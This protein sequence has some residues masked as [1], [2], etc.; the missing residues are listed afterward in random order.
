MSVAR[1]V[2]RFLMKHAYAAAALCLTPYPTT[3]WTIDVTD[4]PDQTYLGVFAPIASQSTVFSLTYDYYL[5]PLLAQFAA[6]CL[7]VFAITRAPG[8]LGLRQPRTF[9][10]AGA[11]VA[12]VCAALS[13]LMFAFY[14]SAGASRLLL[15]YNEDWQD[16]VLM[17]SVF[18]Q[19][20]F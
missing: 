11:A 4:G 15:N 9:R 1:R 7:I 14:S 17:I 13:L 12:W 19:R 5:A 2:I 3:K 6:L 16:R 10:L 8:W 18:D 20:V